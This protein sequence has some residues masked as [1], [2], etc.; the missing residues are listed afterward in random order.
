MLKP[1]VVNHKRAS[2]ELIN[3]LIQS[4]ILEITDEGIRCKE[5]QTVTP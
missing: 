2:W 1:M 4:G 3:A 5:K